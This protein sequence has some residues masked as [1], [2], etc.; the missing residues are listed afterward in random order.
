MWR[1]DTLFVARNSEMSRYHAVVVVGGRG[2]GSGEE[3]EH[4]VPDVV[5]P[6]E[7]SDVVALRGVPRC[8]SRRMFDT[9]VFQWCGGVV[10]VRGCPDESRA[11]RGRPGWVESSACSV[12]P[13]RCGTWKAVTLQ[14][15]GPT[16][17]YAPRLPRHNNLGRGCKICL[18]ESSLSSWYH[19]LAGHYGAMT[20]AS[21]L[22]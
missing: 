1:G 9:S 10:V 19:Y 5:R 17:S 8:V 11:R 16:P 4:E 7:C 22:D 6:D 2:E 3:V 20:A 15:G 14:P 12:E 21:A 13:C 18:S